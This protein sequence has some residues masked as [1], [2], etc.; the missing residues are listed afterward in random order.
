MT[1]QERFMEL[2]NSKLLLKRNITI[3]AIVTPKWK[4]EAQQQLQLQ[5]DRLDSQLQQLE[6]QAQQAVSEL[7]AKST[8][9]LGPQAQQQIENLQMQVNQRKAQ[10]LE[11]K[12]QILQ[13][14]QQVQTVEM[15]QEVNQGQIENFFYVGKGDNLVQKLKVEVVIKDGEII[16]IRGEL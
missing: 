3:V 15:E 12:N 16:D 2:D 14:L 13:Q 6:M 8:Q 1:Y 7:K 10:F 4:E 5:M 11:Q 9:P